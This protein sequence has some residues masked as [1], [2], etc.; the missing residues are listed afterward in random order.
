MLVTNDVM[1]TH[2]PFLLEDRFIATLRLKQRSGSVGLLTQYTL[3]HNSESLQFF[4]HT[5]VV[6]K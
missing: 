5:Q 6:I 4:E 2:N 3:A 1:F